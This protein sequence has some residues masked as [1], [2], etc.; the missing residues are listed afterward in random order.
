MRSTGRLTLGFF[1]LLSLSSCREFYDEEYEEFEATR[2]SQREGQFISYRA[3]LESTD[4]LLPELGGSAS[5]K[6]NDEDV[7]I[8]IDIDGLP[9]N[10]INLHYSIIG[11][12]CSTQNFTIPN[13]LTSTRSARLTESITTRALEADL[14]ATGTVS[15]GIDL[16]GKSLIVKAFSNLV[17]L[18]DTSNVNS[19]VV[20]CGLIEVEDD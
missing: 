6:I 8:S 17:S 9:Q 14:V 15:S 19:I 7:D 5:V 16:R 1:I 3:D 20:A 12:D 18:P 11:A 2:P 10:I 13:N 4:P